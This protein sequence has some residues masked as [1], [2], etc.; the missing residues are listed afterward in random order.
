LSVD[1][2]VREA[3]RARAKLA[4]PCSGAV[5][6]YGPPAGA[7][8]RAARRSNSDNLVC[9]AI[10]AIKK[11]VPDLGILCDVRARSPIPATAMTACC[12]DG[13]IVNDETVAVLVRQALVEGRGRLRTSSRR[14]T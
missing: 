5:S 14:P 8:R 2:A 6:L 9:R 12:G 4:I 1:Q 11:E 10:R 3:V 7:T 13:E